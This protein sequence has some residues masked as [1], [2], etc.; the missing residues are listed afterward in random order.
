MT[1]HIDLVIAIKVAGPL[2]NLQWRVGSH[3]DFDP[4]DLESDAWTFD[5]FFFAEQRKRLADE[6]RAMRKGARDGVQFARTWLNAFKWARKCS[7]AAC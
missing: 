1:K 2:A 7:G 5:A 6:V 4:Q 3:D